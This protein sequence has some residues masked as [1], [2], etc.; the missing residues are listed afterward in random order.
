MKK[1][2]KKSLYYLFILV[3]FGFFNFRFFVVTS[4][5]PISYNIL[6]ISFTVASDLYTSTRIY[7]FYFP[8]FIK[9]SFKL[10]ITLHGYHK[11]SK[12]SNIFLILFI[13]IFQKWVVVIL[14]TFNLLNSCLC[15][16]WRRRLNF[17]LTNRSAPFHSCQGLL[18]YLW[19]P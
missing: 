15:L 7:H 1:L 8:I 14:F 4:F 10:S 5:N 17:W 18:T 3:S 9:L 11:S 13:D 12:K 2:N 6:M 19:R 16:L